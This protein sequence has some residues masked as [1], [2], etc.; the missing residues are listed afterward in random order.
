MLAHLQHVHAEVLVLQPQRRRLMRQLLASL[1][2]GVQP[3]QQRVTLL[4]EQVHLRREHLDRA[5]QAERLRFLLS[6][7]CVIRC[8]ASSV[9][10]SDASASTRR[11]RF[12]AE[13]LGLEGVTWQQVLVA[14]GAA[15]RRRACA[16]DVYVRV[17][18]VMVVNFRTLV[19]RL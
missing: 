7:G 4:L 18:V 9:V 1:A 3:R 19:S 14:V 10:A 6:G 2:H 11:R 13:D 16:P 8:V 5:L 12:R 15:A 17:V